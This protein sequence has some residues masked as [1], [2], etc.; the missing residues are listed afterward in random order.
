[1][2]TF[3]FPASLAASARERLSQSDTP[4]SDMASETGM[5]SSRDSADTVLVRVGLAHR[6]SS[7]CRLS[8]HPI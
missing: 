2:P 4:T 7:E 3:V 8:S 5:Q 6:G 1:M